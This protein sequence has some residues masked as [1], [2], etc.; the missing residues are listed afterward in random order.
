MIDIQEHL[1]S[2]RRSGEIEFS[3]ITSNNQKAGV[4]QLVKNGQVISKAE[5]GGVEN[6]VIFREQVDPKS[7][8]WFRLDVLDEKGHALA[9]TNPLFANV[10]EK[11]DPTYWER[12]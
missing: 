4:A 7:S 9:I 8:D 6:G 1:K 11:G 10:R 5:L 2:A 3:A 12:P